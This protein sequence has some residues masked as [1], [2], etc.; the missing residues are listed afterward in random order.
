M[1]QFTSIDA[2]QREF[3]KRQHVFFVGSSAPGARINLSPKGPDALRVLGPNAAVYL[4]RT[5][6]GNETAAHLLADGRLT[7]MFCAFDGPPLILRLYGS[8]RAIKRGGAEYARL[9]AVEY[10]GI[11]PPGARQMIAL[12]VE[13]VQT[14]C[15]YGVPHLNYVGE[16]PS[17]SKWAEKKGDVELEAYR[18]QYNERSIDGL[19]TGLLDQETAETRKPLVKVAA[20]PILSTT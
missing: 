3:I 20:R 9:L 17:L 10:G 16:R 15:G 18:H 6:S 11:E 5:G 14:S 12:D 1:K 19:P 2:K 13:L 8:G 7:L 4:D